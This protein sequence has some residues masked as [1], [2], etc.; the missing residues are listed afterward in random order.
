MYNIP[1]NRQ[2]NG[3][4][5]EI[6]CHLGPSVL[7]SDKDMRRTCGTQRYGNIGTDNINVFTFSI[8]IKSSILISYSGL[9]VKKWQQ[10]ILITIDLVICNV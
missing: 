1:N 4:S 6:S 10:L 8:D 2:D 7:L 9:V 5:L 3:F